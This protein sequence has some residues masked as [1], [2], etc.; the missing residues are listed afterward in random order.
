M[1]VSTVAAHLIRVC[2]VADTIPLAISTVNN[3]TL[4]VQ[5]QRLQ[6]LP[7]SFRAH[8]PARRTFCT[9]SPPNR[10]QFAA[11]LNFLFAENGASVLERFRRASAAGFRAVECSFGLDVCVADAKAVQLETGLKVVL[12]NLCVGKR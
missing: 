4:Q 9:M 2:S 8:P 5:R 3:N 10:L 6:Q 1:P 11:N 7:Q 12:L